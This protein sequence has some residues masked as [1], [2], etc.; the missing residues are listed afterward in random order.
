MSRWLKVSI[1][2]LILITLAGAYTANKYSSVIFAK[3]AFLQFDEGGQATEPISWFTHTD[4][5]LKKLREEYKLEEKVANCK[6]DYEKVQVITD[7]VHNLWKHD[8]SNA[9]AQNDPLFIL[10]EVEKGQRFR[11]VE[12][13]KVISGCLQALGMQARTLGLKTADVE[14]RPSGAGH[15]GTEVF[16]RDLKKWVFIDGQWNAIPELNG[17][18][19]NAV[20]L[21]SAL[22]EKKA[23]L[24]F[25]KLSMPET[26]IYKK[27]ITPYLYY[28]DVSSSGRRLMLGPVGAKKPTKFQ[29]NSNLT[30]HDY[31]HSVKVFYAEPK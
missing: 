3:A 11:C 23:G 30:V 27:W 13:G 1:V 17:T 26:L 14:T 12:Y 10:H 21:Q 29:I 19:L 15:V 25:P 28:L 7:W 20:E 18:P 8:G 31:T 24:R 2:V 4:D 22:A 5:Y 16:L 6:S 9:P